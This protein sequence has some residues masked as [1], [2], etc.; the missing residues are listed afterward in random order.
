MID[1]KIG[2][3]G[4]RE[5]LCP[6]LWKNFK[7]G[8]VFLVYKVP[9]MASTSQLLNLLQTLKIIIITRQVGIMLL[10]KWLCIAIKDLYM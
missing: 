2:F 4:P 9:L 3:L 5:K 10:H 6:L 8:V 1:I 7:I